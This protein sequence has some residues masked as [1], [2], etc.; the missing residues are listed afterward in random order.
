MFIAF[1]SFTIHECRHLSRHHWFIATFRLLQIAVQP[2]DEACQA[3]PKSEVCPLLDYVHH[4]L[5]IL[6]LVY[7]VRGDDYCRLS[8]NQR[9]AER[10]A[11]VLRLVVSNSVLAGPFLTDRFVQC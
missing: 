8:I 11:L 10:Q 2:F 9:L 6:D 1:M 4:S 7:Y 3:P 5:S